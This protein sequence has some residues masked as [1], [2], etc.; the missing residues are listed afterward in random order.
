MWVYSI[1]AATSAQATQ[2]SSSESASFQTT[3]FNAEHNSV[4]SASATD[5]ATLGAT[6]RSTEVINSWE[7]RRTFESV[8]SLSG[9][10]SA[11]QVGTSNSYSTSESGSLREE[12]S[13]GYTR[14]TYGTT[15]VDS[16]GTT[17]SS[18]EQTTTRTRDSYA[19]TTATQTVAT[20]GGTTATS[21]GTRTIYS[22]TATTTQTF[23]D[24]TSTT[25]ASTVTRTTYG[26]AASTSLT[27]PELLVPVSEA[28]PTEQAWVA[29][30]AV[31]SAGYPSHVA[32]TFTKRTGTLAT[33]SSAAPV[34][35]TSNFGTIQNVT[36][37]TSQLTLTTT[38]TTSTADTYVPAA[39]VYPAT[40]TATRSFQML[41]T[42]TTEVTFPTSTT[43]ATTYTQPSTVFSLGT[44]T[45][46]EFQVSGYVVTINASP[47]STQ[48][49]LMQMTWFGSTTMQSLV[50][51][52]DNYATS[53]S[54]TASASANSPATSTGTGGTTTTTRTTTAAT[55][56]TSF[57]EITYTD[58]TTTTTTFT[59]DVPNGT[60]VDSTFSVLNSSYSSS[61]NPSFTITSE[62]EGVTYTVY[63]FWISYTQINTFWSTTITGITEINAGTGTTRFTTS[64]YELISQFTSDSYESYWDNGGPP[65][66]GSTSSSSGTDTTINTIT[67]TDSGTYLVPPLTDTTS[68]STT[69]TLTYET[70]TT[71]TRTTSVTT[72]ATTAGVT[73]TYSYPATQSSSGESSSMEGLSFTYPQ[74]HS[75]NTFN[76]QPT[77]TAHAFHPKNGF[78]HPDSLASSDPVYD[79]LSVGPGSL[80]WPRQATQDDSGGPITPILFTSEISFVSGATTVF[81]RWD[82]SDSRLHYT[83]LT[84]GTTSTSGT[85]SWD[86]GTP[87]SW[88]SHDSTV[89]AASA[90]TKVGG[91][92]AKS[93][94]G[95][96]VYFTPGVRH[97][98]TNTEGTA[99]ASATSWLQT[100]TVEA[101][102]DVGFAMP[103]RSES[104]WS[105]TT[106]AT[107]WSY[108]TAL[109][110]G[111]STGDTALPVLTLSLNPNL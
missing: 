98:T 46:R 31:D 1:T 40:A 85:L 48:T 26:Y 12:Q 8:N 9:T 89:S 78:R 35:A 45:Y 41:T 111:Q 64:E 103:I 110:V 62:S 108:N 3:T 10:G 88:Y 80:Y 55:N 11:T 32:S 30:V 4:A 102:T 97:W 82:T 70:T 19:S 87:V 61:E 107:R 2:V 90:G 53:A 95:A 20:N 7:T 67:Y 77:W 51:A 33:T 39:S 38:V 37:A 91:I 22:G 92:P 101:G 27:A 84:N 100:P 29:T 54:S 76:A 81:A 47:T 42:V 15:T 72:T 17:T 44:I 23:S 94:C 65:I 24:T 13:L 63:E 83:S 14:S 21:T 105:V 49:A 16:L 99:T 69:T 66:N 59:L 18:S 57:T 36:G 79:A 56:T 75:Q 50:R 73:V 109:S 106:R 25:T 28:E 96:S 5:A 60:T 104:V 58:T 71:A 93:Q 6:T 52:A 43:A 86:G 34:V 74:L 68:T